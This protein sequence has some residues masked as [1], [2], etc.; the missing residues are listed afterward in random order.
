MMELSIKVDTRNGLLISET[1][2]KISKDPQTNMR[3]TD[4]RI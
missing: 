1:A 2:H 4:G 3:Q